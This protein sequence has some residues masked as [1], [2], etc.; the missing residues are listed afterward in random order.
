VWTNAGTESLYLYPR[1]ALPVDITVGMGGRALAD[2]FASGGQRGM[3]P[4]EPEM[5]RAFDLLRAASGQPEAE[6]NRTAQEIWK[7]VVEQQWNI[8]IVGLSPATHGVRVVSDRLENVPE[9]TCIA[10]HC[11]T[12]WSGHPEQWFFR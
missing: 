5:I 9:R 6:R 1:Y 10:Q 7:L 8:G 2:W 12:P 11:R 4:S 3:R